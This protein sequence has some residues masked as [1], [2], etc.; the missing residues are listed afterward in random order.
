MIT[1]SVNQPYIDA[2]YSKEMLNFLVKV[3]Q[4][5]SYTPESLGEIVETIINN[6]TE[7]ENLEE[8]S[9][10]VEKLYKLRRS[11]IE[12]K[13]I[14]IITNIELEVGYGGIAE[15]WLKGESN[16]N[17]DS[18]YIDDIVEEFLKYRENYMASTGCDL[19][20]LIELGLMGDIKAM[21]NLRKLCKKDEGLKELI[22]DVLTTDGAFDTI[23]GILE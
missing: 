7:I 20:R 13:S 1:F 3:Q 5:T 2:M 21:K 11:T 16:L 18:L 22:S 17:L 8:Y 14:P 9:K 19:Y 15:D 6:R 10:K 23:K 4:G 12:K